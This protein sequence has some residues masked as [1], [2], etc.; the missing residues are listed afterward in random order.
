MVGFKRISILKVVAWF[1]IFL[2]PALFLRDVHAQED[3]PTP[4]ATLDSGDA[5]IWDLAWQ[6]FGG[7]ALAIAV[8][9]E[10]RLYSARL[11]LL[12]TFTG[13]TEPVYGLSWH[14]K[15]KW[16]ASASGDQT[17]RIWDTRTGETIKTLKG[18]TGAVIH[19]SWS[20]DGS[21]LASVSIDHI[22]TGSNQAYVFFSAW[23]WDVSD[24][25]EATYLYKILPYMGSAAI[26]WS[27]D[28]TQLLTTSLIS[29]QPYDPS[30]PT[31]AINIWD[32]DDGKV[33]K[34]LPFSYNFGVN[35]LVPGSTSLAV[36]SSSEVIEII[37]S[38]TDQTV[39]LLEGHSAPILN[40]DWSPDGTRLASASLDK[41][42]RVWQVST[43]QTLLVLDEPEAISNT[44]WSRDGKVL[45]V[46][47]PYRVQIWDMTGLP[48]V[49]PLSTPSSSDE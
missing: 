25:K 4:L 28:G 21:K 32:A 8:D 30:L 44:K 14:P 18:Y 6:P 26:T 12:K 42:I 10:V 34:T 1:A 49:T 29:D 17:V 13:H 20:P 43:A 5:F 48:A 15:G 35:A 16:L 41:T 40:L 23:V 38:S 31:S 24:P 45:A 46:A 39:I 37:D 19:L 47:T 11:Q 27:H 7:S 2:L 36:A 3:T 33:Q 9:K 22:I